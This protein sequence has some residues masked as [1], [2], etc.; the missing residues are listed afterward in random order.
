MRETR[1]ANPKREHVTTPVTG[2]HGRAGRSH[3]EDATQGD[4]H[5]R[6]GILKHLP[7]HSIDSVR[8]LQIS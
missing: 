4:G 1:N 6:A 5:H 2:D 3:S 8:P 7:T